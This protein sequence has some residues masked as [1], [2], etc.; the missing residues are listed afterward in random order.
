MIAQPIELP[1]SSGILQRAHPFL[2]TGTLMSTITDCPVTPS[3]LSGL[4]PEM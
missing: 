2:C 4:A 1:R 3:V